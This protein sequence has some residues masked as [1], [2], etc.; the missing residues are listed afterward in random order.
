L[1]AASDPAKEGLAI[2]TGLA[3]QIKTVPGIRGIHVLSGGN[4]ALA[5]EV[6]KTAGLA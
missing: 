1:R 5:A 4:E 6:I 3:A 2:A